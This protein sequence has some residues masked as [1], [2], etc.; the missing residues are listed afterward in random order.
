MDGRLKLWHFAEF[1][2]NVNAKC[3]KFI[4]FFTFYRSKNGN[5]STPHLA[6]CIVVSYTGSVMNCF[7]FS[8]TAAVVYIFTFLPLKTVCVSLCGT[9]QAGNQLISFSQAIVNLHTTCMNS[10]YIQSVDVLWRGEFKNM[11]YDFR[12]T[13]RRQKQYLTH[14]FSMYKANTNW[15]DF[16]GP[17][18]GKHFNTLL[19]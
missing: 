15:M 10:I 14:A 12:H 5:D 1:H 8:S 19:I 17:N 7:K 2:L 16:M 4:C 18:V 9:S 3:K 13:A 6:G 11:Y